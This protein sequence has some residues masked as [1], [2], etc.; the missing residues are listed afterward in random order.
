MI[1]VLHIYF[2]IL[3][4]HVEYRGLESISD[5]CKRAYGDTMGAPHPLADRLLLSE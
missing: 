4:Y 5:K 2:G 3:V 1:V